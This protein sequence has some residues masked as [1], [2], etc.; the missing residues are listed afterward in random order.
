MNKGDGYLFK[1]EEYLKEHKQC[2][3]MLNT[4]VIKVARGPMNK[5]DKIGSRQNSDFT[6]L[7]DCTA[8]G[9]EDYVKAEAVIDCTGTY[10]NGNW[11][12]RGGL[13]APGERRME[14]N[15]LRV[16]PDPLGGDRDT[17]ANKVTTVVGSGYSAITTVKALVDLAAEEGNE[18]TRIKWITR[19]PTNPYQ[20]IEDDPLPMR[21]KLAEFG[22]DLAAAKNPQVEYV[23]GYDIVRITE[24][25][26]QTAILL[27]AREG[28]GH[29]V[30]AKEILCDN[31]CSLV[32]Y[33]PDLEMQRE[34]Q[35]HLCYA[36]EGPMKLAA[37]MLAA[38]GGGGDCMKQ[39]APGPATLVSPEKGFFTLGMKSYGRG[40]AYL[41]RI[42]NEQIPMI[43]SLLQKGIVTMV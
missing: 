2:R 34:L 8:E 42:G 28:S 32:G 29:E 20:I 33:R 27:N 30:E 22:N 21:A 24:V 6:V 7:V 4:R 36:T 10:G 41:L 43:I 1:L 3:V 11:L 40:S 16:I 18:A 38:G 23:G 19:R 9:K 25:E 17:Y 12:G 26:G 35:V 5:G 37:A 14:S 39:V 13:P 15:I 31:L